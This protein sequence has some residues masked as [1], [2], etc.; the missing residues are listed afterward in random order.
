MLYD[1]LIVVAL[2]VAY[3]GAVWLAGEAG[4]WILEKELDRDEFKQED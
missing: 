3:A 1:V 4:F 2:T